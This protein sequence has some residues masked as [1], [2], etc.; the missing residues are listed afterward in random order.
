MPKS[1]TR[2]NYR[3]RNPKQEKPI[4]VI[5]TEGE[6]TEY[7]YFYEFKK[8]FKDTITVHILPTGR[9]GNSA[10]KQVVKRIENFI[11]KRVSTRR[12]NDE[13]WAVIDFDNWGEEQILEAYNECQEN[14]YKLAVSNPCFELWLNFHQDNP[15]TPKTC[16]YCQKELRKLLKSYDKN[17]YDVEKLLEKLDKAMEKSAQLH[18]DK[19]EPFPKDTG[20][21]VYL[22]IKSLPDKSE[23]FV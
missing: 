5:A 22:L 7:I 14:R 11:G 1:R 21:H 2:R 8:K 10:P 23:I 17:K 3:Q 20:T 4:F 16:S 9:D 13:F 12:K 19:D 15:K 6:I 18:L